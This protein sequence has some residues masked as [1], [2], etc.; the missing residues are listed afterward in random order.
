[1]RTLLVLGAA[2]LALTVAGQ[3]ANAAESSLR[4][5]ELSVAT[6]APGLDRPTLKSAAQGELQQLDGSKVRRRVVVSLALDS[7]TDGQLAVSVR[8]MLRDAKSGTM[9]AIVQGRARSDATGSVELRQALLRAA[10]H[11][12]VRQIPEALTRG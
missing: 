11:S 6:A 4:L 2:M 9:I 5:G 10:V 1:M 3:N 7:A 8:A 12:A